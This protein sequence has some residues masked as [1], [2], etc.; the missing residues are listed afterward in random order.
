M[1][2]VELLENRIQ[3]LENMLSILVRSDR[4][5]FQKDLQFLDGRN[6]QLSSGTGTKIGTSATQKLGFFGATPVVQQQ[7]LGS[8]SESGIDSDGTARIGINRINT[9][10]INL[11]LGFNT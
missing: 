8:L 11:G 9:A 6:I 5:T 4:Y 3:T 2:K 7:V 1:D 10:L